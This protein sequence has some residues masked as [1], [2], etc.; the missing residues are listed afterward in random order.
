MKQQ[1]SFYIPRTYATNVTSIV[2]FSQTLFLCFG[3]YFK[4]FLF[5]HLKIEHKA[6]KNNST[7]ICINKTLWVCFS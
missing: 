4:T 7:F 3:W 2:M 1:K 5:N 6:I